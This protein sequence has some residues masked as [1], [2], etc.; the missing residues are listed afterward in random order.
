MGY[1]VSEPFLGWVD[2]EDPMKVVMGIHKEKNLSFGANK[3]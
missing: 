2:L 1:G 3:K